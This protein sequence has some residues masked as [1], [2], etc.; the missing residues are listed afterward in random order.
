MTRGDL[1]A[2]CNSFV[3]EAQSSPTVTLR[4]N[5]NVDDHSAFIHDS[6]Q[7]MLDAIHLMEA[8]DTTS[9]PEILVYFATLFPDRARRFGRKSSETSSSIRLHLR[10]RNHEIRYLLGEVREHP[11]FDSLL[12]TAEALIEKAQS[13]FKAYTTSTK[14]WQF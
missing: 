5:Q 13:S 2:T 11:G 1:A 12:N 14:I 7:I 8:A 6:P 10:T 3:K 9:E 4:L